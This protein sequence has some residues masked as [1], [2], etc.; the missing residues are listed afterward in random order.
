[1]RDLS[2]TCCLH[3][4]VIL[5]VTCLVSLE[6]RRVMDGDLMMMQLLGSRQCLSRAGWNAALCPRA[7]VLVSKERCV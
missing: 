4:H 6:K 7:S 2:L 3:T 5:L 1:M